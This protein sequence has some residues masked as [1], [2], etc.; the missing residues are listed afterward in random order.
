L[1]SKLMHFIECMIQEFSI[2]EI[3]CVSGECSVRVVEVTTLLKYLDLEHLQ[4][5]SGSLLHNL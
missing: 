1:F 4:C 5:W 2:A 3:V